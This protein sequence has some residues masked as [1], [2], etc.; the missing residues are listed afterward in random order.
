MR[1][2]KKKDIDVLSS[3]HFSFVGSLTNSFDFNF[4]FQSAYFLIKKYPE[5]KFIICGS[6]DQFNDLVEKSMNF[7]NVQII[8]EISKFEAMILVNNHHN[9]SRLQKY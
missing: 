4:I 7:K 3:K 2:W 5:Y 8:G 9:Q 6:G 1:Q